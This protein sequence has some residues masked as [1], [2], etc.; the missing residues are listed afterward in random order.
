M[1][2]VATVVLGV[3]TG[4]GGGG[5]ANVVLTITGI[6]TFIML[7]VDSKVGNTIMDFGVVVASFFVSKVV[8][9][10]IVVVPVVVVDVV[11]KGANVVMLLSPTVVISIC[12]TVLV[13]I[14]VLIV[15]VVRSTSFS[16][17]TSL[18]LG[19]MFCPFAVAL[20]PNLQRFVNSNDFLYNVGG[21]VFDF[22][23]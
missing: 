20:S 17:K 6:V 16:G 10:F 8:L 11:V 7:C 15:V 22:C 2:F 1:V 3:V 12:S 5:F 9:D 18:I 13:F 14:G 23:C 21:G 4:G 19:S